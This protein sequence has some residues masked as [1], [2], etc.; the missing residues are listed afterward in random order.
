MSDNQH[1]S[2][3]INTANDAM[4]ALASALNRLD[5]EAVEMVMNITEGWMV[6]EEEA[7]A[8]REL[9]SAIATAIDDLSGN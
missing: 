9:T 6:T 7:L 2:T 4:V 5:Q 1:P 3:R 8:W